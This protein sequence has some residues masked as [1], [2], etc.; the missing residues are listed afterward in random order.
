MRWRRGYAPLV[1]TVSVRSPLRPLLLALTLAAAVLAACSADDGR[2]LPPPSPGQTNTT[3]STPV[4]PSEVGSSEVF[5][6]QSNAFAEGAEIPARF[7]CTGVDISPDLTWVA[8]PVEAVE[9]ALVVRDRDAEGFLHWVVAGIDPFVFGFGEGGV[10]ENAVEALNDAGTT[11][12]LGPCPP[13]GSGT[14]SYEFVLH[15]LAEVSG[16]VPG[17]AATEA[18]TRIESISVGQAVL[19]GTVTAGGTETSAGDSVSV[20]EPSVE[21]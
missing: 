15:A 10:P 4:V 16:V 5:E 1:H 21:G 6:L 3:P 7:T 17:L 14:H 11:G 2:A 19:S 8:V 18:A 13:S 9:L 12:W 20:N